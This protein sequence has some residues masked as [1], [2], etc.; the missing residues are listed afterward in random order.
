MLFSVVGCGSKKK[1]TEINKSV[2]KEKKDLSVFTQ[3][4]T[5]S[6]ITFTKDATEMIIEPDVPNNP[7]I[8][9]KDTIIGAKSVKYRKVKSDSTAQVTEQV[10]EQV[11]DKGEV[12]D[13]STVKNT[14]MEREDTSGNIK[15]SIWGIVVILLGAAFAYFF[16]WKKN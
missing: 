14:G 11:E 2:Y 3:K 10:T 13:N 6:V 4:N 7:L 16:I 8:I 9:G 1:T 12:K 5:L 15:W